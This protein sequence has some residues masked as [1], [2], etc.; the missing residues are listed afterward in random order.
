MLKRRGGLGAVFVFSIA[1][2]SITLV[3]YQLMSLGIETSKYNTI[4]QYGRD[5]LLILETQPTVEKNYLVNIKEKLEEKLIN[6]DEES[7]DMILN[8]NNTRYNVDNMPITIKSDF[9]EVVGI[10][11][12]YNYKPT[13]INFD[14]IIASKADIG[15]EEMGID[16][17]TIS[18]NRGTSDG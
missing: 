9:G 13:R 7:I 16:F 5:V 14:G 11:I 1:I 3:F 6:N 10:K 15:L 4:N 8:I 18:K 2:T 12:T 17:E